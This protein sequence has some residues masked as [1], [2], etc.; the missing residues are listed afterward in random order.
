MGNVLIV[1]PDSCLHTTMYFFIGNLSLAEVWY[2]T[3]TAHKMLASFLVEQ[4]TISASGVIGQY[5]FLFSFAATEMLLLAVM[6]YGQYLAL[7]NPLRYSTIKNPRT[8]QY[9]A[10]ACW[11]MGFICLMF[12]SCMLARI[13]FCTP[14]RINNFF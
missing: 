6:V 10:M 13:S 9:L 11:L 5:Y 3:I 12:E 14:N 7:C 1:L 2:T 8:C 4:S